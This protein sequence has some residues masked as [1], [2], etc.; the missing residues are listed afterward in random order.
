MDLIGRPFLEGIFRAAVAAVEPGHLVRMSLKRSSS[1]I[2]LEAGVV[3]ASLPWEGVQNV[4]LVGGGKAG[5]AMGE[6]ALE[7]LG[8]RVGEGVIAVPHGSGG[9]AG[10]VRFVGAG[11]PLPDAGSRRA[12]KA[13]MALL[14]G[15]GEWDLVIALISGGGSALIS[16]PARGV[17]PDD[18]EV[19]LRRL[20]RSGADITEFNTVRKHLS[21]VKGGR[22]AKAAHPARAWALLLSDVPGD[23]PSVIASGPFSPDPTTYVD[24]RS[25]LLRRDILAKT[26]PS[27]RGHIGSGVA[28]KIP[29]TLKPGDPVFGNVVG[30]LIGSN[31][32]A[33]EAAKAA[34]ER[35]GAGMARVLPGFLRGEARE[36]ARA[37]VSELRSASASAPTGHVVILAAGGETT[38]TVR[39][40]GR[41]GRNQEFALAAAIELD[42]EEGIAILSAGTDVHPGRHLRKGAGRG[43]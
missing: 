14:S 10:S 13:M 16:A 8:D 11:H 40:K 34:A 18:K 26:P 6:A 7:I 25:I 39:G 35:E 17:S 36:C 29:E 3:S 32:V 21:L 9:M 37:F 41:G 28:G 27:V 31:R 19:A 23:E 30:A 43:S 38:V 5:R 12:A 42:G 20:L 1:G 24:A 33:L 15:A 4:Y 2:S 22:M